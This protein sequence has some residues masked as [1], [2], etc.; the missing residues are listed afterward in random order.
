MKLIKAKP[1][2]SNKGLA[3][4][5]MRKIA[6]LFIPP[7]LLYAMVLVVIAIIKK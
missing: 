7:F 1:V 3:C 4:I 6:L 2:Q 5:K